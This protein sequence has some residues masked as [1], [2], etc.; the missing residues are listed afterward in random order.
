[1]GSYPIAA[2]L[3]PAGVLGNY[4]ISSNAVFFTITQAA[5][6]ITFGPLANMTYGDPDLTVTSAGATASSGLP[7]TFTAASGSCELTNTGTVH[8]TNTGY[9]VIANAFIGAL[10]DRFDADIPYVSIDQLAKT[11]PLVFPGIEPPDSIERHVDQSTAKSLR[12]TFA[13]PPGH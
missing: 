12:D 10:N 7:V 13:K 2:T 4:N 5:Q 6:T 8:P 11:D 1:M 9:G 3:S